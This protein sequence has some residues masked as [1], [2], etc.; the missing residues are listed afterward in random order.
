MI[1]ERLGQYAQLMRMDKPVGTLL[2]LWPT[3]WALWLASLVPTA[4]GVLIN[5]AINPHVVVVFLCGVFL[6]RGAGC[7]INDF[8]D[9]DIDK[10]VARTHDRPLT[11]GKI[12]SIEAVILFSVLSL[13]AAALVWTLPDNV[14]LSV[15]LW[16]IPAV[17][18]VILYPFTKRFF[19]TPQLV[20]GIA[21]SFGIPMAFV[22]N[23]QG[24][25]WGVVSIMLANIAW[26]VAYDTMY[27]MADRVDDVKIGVRSSA[28][29]FGHRDRMI[30][31]TLQIVTL[32][33][34]LGVGWFYQL[35][36]YYF[37]ALL[38]S[39][40]FFAYQQWLIR[41]RHPQSCFQAFLNNT[42]VGG[43]VWLGILLGVN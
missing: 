30:V 40:L 23:G 7:V 12:R 31:A 5:Q 1:Q 24:L 17:F 35:N 25:S 36:N 15:F 42:W 43:I 10:H 32:L 22:A 29:F 38:L 27:A 8:A 6:M 13:T 18:F 34:W 21:F 28:I 14:R 33:M 11:S 19:A 39:A 20:L 16:S 4:Q 2:L 37:A 3:C 9:R 41:K 26:V